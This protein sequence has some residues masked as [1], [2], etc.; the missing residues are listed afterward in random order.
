[1]SASGPV[2]ADA[3]SPVNVVC[4]VV[5]SDPD[6]DFGK[7]QTFSLSRKCEANVA[8][9]CETKINI[10]GPPVKAFE[11]VPECMRSKAPAC[12]RRDAFATNCDVAWSTKGPAS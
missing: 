5:V 10:E 6:W 9:E 12:T 8:W 1:M 7:P 11:G 4:D 2:V 3:F